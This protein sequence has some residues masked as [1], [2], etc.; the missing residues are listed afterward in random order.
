MKLYFHPSFL[1]SWIVDWRCDIG[2]C[3]EEG[4]SVHVRYYTLNS[5]F[6]YRTTVIF[7]PV[8]ASVW[9]SPLH[10]FAAWEMNRS[11]WKGLDKRRLLWGLKPHCT[12]HMES[13]VL[14]GVFL[15]VP[16]S[17]LTLM[18]IYQTW[19]YFF[20]TC[21]MSILFKNRNDHFRCFKRWLVAMEQWVICTPAR[22][23]ILNLYHFNRGLRRVKLQ[24]PI[25]H[26]SD[27][28]NRCLKSFMVLLL[29]LMLS[30][31]H[32][33]LF[34]SAILPFVQLYHN[35]LFTHKQ[36]CSRLCFL[37]QWISKW[38]IGPT[39]ASRKS[40]TKWDTVYVL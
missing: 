40:P 8:V 15:S 23:L 14:T 38:C 6:T 19:G 7:S 29:F 13:L 28:M 37:N 21:R 17:F 4:M 5:Q 35:S 10:V 11:E 25:I 12:D 30:S 22:H 9:I 20:D 2:R 33:L 32:T 16:G 27:D 24:P 26:S 34:I 39:R 3:I 31:L 1:P 36:T 18:S